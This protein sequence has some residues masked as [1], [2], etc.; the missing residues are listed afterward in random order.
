MES[1]TVKFLEFDVAEESSYSQTIE[2]NSKVGNIIS[3]SLPIQIIVKTP[4]PYTELVEAQD[5][6]VETAPNEVPQGS[7]VQDEAIAT[8]VRRTIKER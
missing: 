1:Q 6:F 4:T 3:L 8:L 2:D 7:Q 5:L